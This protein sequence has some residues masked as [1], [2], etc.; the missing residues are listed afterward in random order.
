MPG[1]LSW[2]AILPSGNSEVKMLVICALT[3]LGPRS[4]LG[5]EGAED[6]DLALRK[7][8]SGSDPIAVG[9]RYFTANR[10]IVATGSYGALFETALL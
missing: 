10:A 9:P 6:A 3:S 8:L 7:C 2:Q 4:D 5:T 1:V